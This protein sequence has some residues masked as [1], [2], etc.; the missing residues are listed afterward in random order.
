MR[1]IVLMLAV[2]ALTALLVAGTAGAGTPAAYQAQVSSICRGYTPVYK[3]L[4]GRYNAAGKKH[5]QYTMG[6]TLGQIFDLFL[7]ENGRVEKVPVPAALKAPM[8]PILSQLRAVDS[9]IRLAHSRHD[10]SE[11]VKASNLMGPLQSMY[12]AIGLRSC[13]SDQ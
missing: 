12:D 11:I 5:D 9:H 10:P 3:T 1:T 6:V 8:A 4:E 13:G 2:T 7:E